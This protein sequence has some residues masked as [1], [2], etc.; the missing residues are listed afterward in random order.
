MTYYLDEQMINL[1]QGD[2]HVLFH[3]RNTFEVAGLNFVL[4]FNTLNQTEIR[5]LLNRRDRAFRNAQLMPPTDNFFPF[6][7]M[8]SLNMRMINGYILH[9]NLGAGTEGW[10]NAAVNRVGE[11]FALKRVACETGSKMSKFMNEVNIH[12]SICVSI[13]R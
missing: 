4:A 9:D 10:V 1:Y 13:K 11:P 7:Y 8:S 6:R 3:T 5:A 12:R 2:N